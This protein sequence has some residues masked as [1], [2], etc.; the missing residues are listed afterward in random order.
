MPYSTTITALDLSPGVANVHVSAGYAWDEVTGPHPGEKKQ[1]EVGLELT[2]LQFLSQSNPPTF[3]YAGNLAPQPKADWFIALWIQESARVSQDWGWLFRSGA[4]TTEPPSE[5]IEVILAQEQPIGDSDLAGAVSTP[6][7]SGSTRVT[8]VTSMVNGSDI[9]F[10]ATGTDTHLPSGDTFTLTATL[11]LIPNSKVMDEQSPFEIEFTNPHLSFAAGTGHGFET[12]ILNALSGPIWGQIESQ[13]HGTIKGLLERGGPLDRRDEDQ[14]GRASVHARRGRPLDPEPEG[15][16]ADEGRWQRGAG[17]RRAR[18]PRRF[19]RCDE[20]VPGTRGRRALLRRDGSDQS[21]CTRGARP[22]GLA[23]PAP[24][25]LPRGRTADL[26][27][28]AGLAAARVVGGA[29]A[30]PARRRAKTRCRACVAAGGQLV[31]SRPPLMSLHRLAGSSPPSLTADADGVR[32][33]AGW[34]EALTEPA[35]SLLESSR[36]RSRRSDAS[37]NS[38]RTAQPCGRPQLVRWLFASRGRLSRNHNIITQLQPGAATGTWL[39]SS[40]RLVRWLRRLLE[41]D[42]RLT[43]Q[44]VALAVSALINPQEQEVLI[45][46]L[47]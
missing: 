9:D 45:P 35:P 28:R 3:S 34:R 4:F 18:R 22:A 40:P 20:Q 26:R 43:L 16:D 1:E 13:I 36:P 24:S 5:P 15:D 46:G 47:R 14:P 27:V 33:Q 30:P 21:G 17:N 8:S 6:T 25:P 39:R 7:T 11:K 42:D 2:S 31:A 10:T 32:H 41:D 23:R 29:N 38:P 19:R 44:E 12:A 37:G